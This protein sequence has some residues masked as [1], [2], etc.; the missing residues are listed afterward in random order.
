MRVQLADWRVAP[1][2]VA[3]LVVLRGSERET[4]AGR[5]D[6]RPRA[7][8]RYGVVVVDVFARFARGN[9]ATHATYVLI[10]QHFCRAIRFQRAR[11]S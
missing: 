9:S 7:N 6:K 10:S 11:F 8:W 4:T 3:L 2:S 1:G 5:R